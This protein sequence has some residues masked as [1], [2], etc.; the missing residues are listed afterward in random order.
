MPKNGFVYVGLGQSINF[1]FVDKNKLELDAKIREIEGV[2]K[3][4]KENEFSARYFGYCFGGGFRGDYS[5]SPET[6]YDLHL[7]R[8]PF[9]K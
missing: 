4:S 3:K 6:A 5:G 9:G 7:R 2:G 1:G 8:M